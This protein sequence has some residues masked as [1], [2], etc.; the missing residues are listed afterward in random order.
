MD[1][2]DLAL[3]AGQWLETGGCSGP[4]CADLD[5][6]TVVDLGD[7]GLLGEEWGQ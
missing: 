2:E 6:S 3:F 5:G 4:G 7:C 1:E